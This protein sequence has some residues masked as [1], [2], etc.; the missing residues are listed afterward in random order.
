MRVPEYLA[1]E[2]SLSTACDTV[3][4]PSETLEETHMSNPVSL[5]KETNQSIVC[6]VVEISYETLVE[7]N[8][9]ECHFLSQ[10]KHV[11]SRRLSLMSQFDVHLI[12]FLSRRKM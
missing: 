11:R 8:M 6:D 5:A 2:K 9:R 3:E 1:E 10:D 7:I 12:S 4:I